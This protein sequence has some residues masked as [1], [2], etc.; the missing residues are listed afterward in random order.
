MSA[1]REFLDTNVL[2]YAFSLDAK[3]AIAENLLARGCMIGV[4][5]LDEFAN[6]ARR[7][8]G[9]S[10][11]ETNEALASIRTLSRTIAPV[12]IETHD[13]GMR[14]AQEHGFAMFDALMIAAALRLGCETFWSED[15]HSGMVVEGRMKIFNPF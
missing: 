10:W 11:E 5:G 8:L 13:E 1:A 9:M 14:L 4:Q 3:A 15:M 12:D 7:K 2:I 6:A